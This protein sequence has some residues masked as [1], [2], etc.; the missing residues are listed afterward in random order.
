ME[1]EEIIRQVQSFREQYKDPRWLLAYR[2]NDERSARSAFQSIVTS[3]KGKE[4]MPSFSFFRFK[5]N[6]LSYVALLGVEVL[7]PDHYKKIQLTMNKGVPTG[8]SQAAVS[9]LYH[10]QNL[11]YGS[12]LDQL[13]FNNS[14]RN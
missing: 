13:N 9:D 14:S 5:Q 10:R 11:T 7:S 2:F 4:S 3:I 6:G 12:M 1:K 8:L